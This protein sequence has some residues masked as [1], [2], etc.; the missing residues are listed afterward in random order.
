[1]ILLLIIIKT[2]WDKHFVFVLSVYCKGHHTA[3]ISSFELN[4]TVHVQCVGDA[5]KI[6]YIHCT[7]WI[8]WISLG[9]DY[10]IELS[11]A[12]CQK[13][14]GSFFRRLRSGWDVYV[15]WHSGQFG[16]LFISWVCGCLLSDWVWKRILMCDCLMSVPLC[17]HVRLLVT[18]ALCFLPPFFL[19]SKG[20]VKD[21]P[22]DE[23]MKWRR[24][25]AA[26]WPLGSCGSEINV[27]RC[28]A[29]QVAAAPGSRSKAG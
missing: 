3:K 13:K 24:S 22:G 10:M 21:G 26:H 29:G 16:M 23:L 8:V 4:G 9:S 17:L 27:K 25:V 14:G 12:A 15:G 19:L 18:A 1:M 6:Q 28:T 5:T 20:A 2:K 11:E 7:V